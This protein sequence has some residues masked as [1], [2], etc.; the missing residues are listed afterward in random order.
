[1]GVASRPLVII[2][3]SVVHILF[4]DYYSEQVRMSGDPCSLSNPHQ[5]TVSHWHLNAFPN[6]STKIISGELTVRC[7]V[8]SES[9]TNQLVS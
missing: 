9:E 7:N 8:I 5:V 1:M 3:L 6:F 2:L 4:L